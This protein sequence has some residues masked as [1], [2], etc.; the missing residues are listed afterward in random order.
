[1]T[2]SP[3]AEAQLV[4]FRVAPRPEQ[5]EG[6]LLLPAPPPENWKKIENSVLRKL[7]LI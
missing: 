1:M 6:T 7:I 4:R 2:I 5:D 3:E